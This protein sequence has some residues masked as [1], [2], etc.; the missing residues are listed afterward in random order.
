MPSQPSSPFSMTG[1]S[2]IQGEY[3]WGQ[4]VVELKSVN[5]RFLEVNL[6]APD[7]LK[8]L[9]IPFRE[10]T[11]KKA[12]TRQVRYQRKFEVGGASQRQSHRRFRGA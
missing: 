5:H 6:R 7:L 10:A 3:P 4:L 2:R 12:A 1:F 8:S 11:R 9:E